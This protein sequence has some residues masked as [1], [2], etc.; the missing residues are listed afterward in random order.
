MMTLTKNYL[1]KMSGKRCLVNNSLYPYLCQEFATPEKK[2]CLLCR[3]NLPSCID[4]DCPHCRPDMLMFLEI[5]HN[6]SN[7]IP[8]GWRQYL[9]HRIPVTPHMTGIRYNMC[10]LRC[11]PA[12]VPYDIR[13]H[14]SLCMSHCSNQKHVPYLELL[15]IHMICIYIKPPCPDH[16]RETFMLN[17]KKIPSMTKR[18]FQIFNDTF[19]MFDN[20]FL[21]ICPPRYHAFC[22]YHGAQTY[23]FTILFDE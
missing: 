22:K 9:S 16:D 1:W 20:S 3:K 17:L 11:Q 14:L 18:F 8:L 21:Y 12:E 2:V 13:H 5:M 10:T 23:G 6:P 7:W 4:Y 15:C 19:K